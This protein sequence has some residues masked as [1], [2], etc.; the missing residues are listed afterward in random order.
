MSTSSS[1]EDD[2]YML[3]RFTPLQSQSSNILSYYAPNQSKKKR[4]GYDNI[5][6]IY[7]A[8]D[9]TQLPIV[10]YIVRTITREAMYV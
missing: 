9:R 1:F 8:E 6:C 4:A 5:E 2:D 7:L 3:K 10:V